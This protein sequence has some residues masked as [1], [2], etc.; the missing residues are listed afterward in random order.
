VTTRLEVGRIGRAHGLNGEVAVTFTTNRDERHAVGSELFA[1]ERRLVVESVRP[2]QQRW[3]IRFAG[4]D[5]RDAAEELRGVLLTAEPLGELGADEAWAHDLI[6]CE[7]RDTSDTWCGEVV[8]LEAN[9]AGDLLVLDTGGL[10]PMQFVLD[11]VDG[12]VRIDPPE[13]LLS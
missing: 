2:H 12:V 7:V 11:H 10:V 3:L 13:G 5:D 1:G 8:A 9:P 6:G 4:I